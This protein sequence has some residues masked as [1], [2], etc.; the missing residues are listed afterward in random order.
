[1][2]NTIPPTETTSNQLEYLLY[3]SEDFCKILRLSLAPSSVIHESNVL[4][5][6]FK[7]IHVSGKQYKI[8]TQ[9]D[10][11]AYVASQEWTPH[12][13]AHA[14]FS[15]RRFY[16]Y[17]KN[18]G[19]VQEN[20]AADIKIV[21]PK[22]QHLVQS[23]T[24]TEIKAVFRK[25][26]KN[27]SMQGLRNRLLVEFAYGSGLRAAEIAT[28]NIGDVAL[29]QQTAHVLGKGRKERVVP[30]TNR[31][32]VVFKRYCK[33]IKETRSALFVQIKGP[34]RGQRLSPSSVGDTI[35]RKTKYHAH[36]FRHACATHML[37]SGCNI[38]YIQ[39]LLGHERTATTQIYTRLRNE[40]L[41]Q[42]INQKHPCAS[43]II[44]LNYMKMRKLDCSH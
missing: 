13:R 42:V 23:P 19:L 30:L 7:H 8:I 27:K 6:F 28:L 38:R 3:L 24:L 16:E 35:R 11:E 15:I 37:L 36:L 10:I 31:C 33:T 1:M 12:T 21:Y 17:L 41:R 9:T 20:P 44:P 4:Q 25:L 40:E 29:Q 18:N 34:N 5:K 14:L 2:Q 22:K 39:E 26:E 32:V 43:R